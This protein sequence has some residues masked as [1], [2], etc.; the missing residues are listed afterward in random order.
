KTA[1]ED[2][3]RDDDQPQDTLEPKTDKTPKQDW[4]KQPP[5]PPT[6]NPE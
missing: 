5:R 2:V 3:V 6:P 4:F 1:A